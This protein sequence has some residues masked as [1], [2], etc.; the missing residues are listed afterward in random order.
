MSFWLYS[1]LCA[2]CEDPVGLVAMMS[3]AGQDRGWL[4]SWSWLWRC[5]GSVLPCFWHAQCPQSHHFV[6]SIPP[7]CGFGALAWMLLASLWAALVALTP[8]EHHQDLQLLCTTD[9]KA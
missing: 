6:L 8:P 3:V 1:K 5:S 2:G 4:L 7:V 9:S